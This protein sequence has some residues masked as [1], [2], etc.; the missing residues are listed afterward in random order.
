[1]IPVGDRLSDSEEL[2]TQLLRAAG[3]Q[4]WFREINDRIFAL[5]QDASFGDYWCECAMISCSEAICLSHVDYLG[6]RSDPT[7]FV[8]VPGQ[9]SSVAESVVFATDRYLIVEKLGDTA[10]LATRS[11]YERRAHPG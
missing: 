9:V 6:L 5:C 3:V 4:A 11:V 1:V 7:H 2:A 8:V 10:L